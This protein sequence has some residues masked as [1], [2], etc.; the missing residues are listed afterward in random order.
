M[1]KKKKAVTDGT[2]DDAIDR[3]KEGESPETPT[4]EAPPENAE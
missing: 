2:V 1:A 3:A 4:E